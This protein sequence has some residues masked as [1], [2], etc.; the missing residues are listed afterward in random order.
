VFVFFAVIAAS[1][2]VAVAVG[3][4][5][6]RLSQIRVN[7]PELLIAAF[8]VKAVVALLGVAHSVL[9]VAVARPLNIVGA[10]LLLVVVW[11]NRRIPG[12][13]IFGAGLLLNLVAILA[14]GGRMPVVLPADVD[15]NSPTL[16]ALRT[17][18]DPLHVWLQHPHGLWF[19]GDIFS[20]PTLGGHHSLVS[21]GDLLMS[22]GVA[23]LIVRCSQKA[24]GAHPAYGPSPSR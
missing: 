19:I 3:G 15:L 5:I 20:I 18:L 23:W 22:A 14:F 7:R 9:A 8:G 11:L 16:A 21:I 24:S 1:L 6:R 12:A 17:G 2:V 10:V 4:D 13:N